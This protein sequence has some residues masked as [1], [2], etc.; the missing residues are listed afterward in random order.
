VLMKIQ[1]Q[2]IAQQRAPAISA[3]Q[4]SAGGTN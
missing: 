1:S 4:V 2:V 3:E